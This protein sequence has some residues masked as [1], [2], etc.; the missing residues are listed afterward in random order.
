MTVAG[1][2]SRRLHVAY[3][4]YYVLGNLMAMQVPFVGFNVLLQAECASSH[5]IFVMVNGFSLMVWFRNKVSARQAKFLLRLAFVTVVGLTAFAILAVILT[6]R[7]Q[8]TGRALSL[9][10]PTYAK[11]YIPIIASVSEHQPTTWTS[12]FFDLHMLVPFAPAG[13]FFLFENPTDGKIF[14][15]LYGT[16]AWYF[17]GVMVRLMLT[18]APV[19]S[20]LASVGVSALLRRFMGH[21]KAKV[22]DMLEEDERGRREERDA[23]QKRAARA[24]KKRRQRSKKAGS[25][26]DGED[27]D[28]PDADGPDA[29][30]PDAD[31]PD[32]D[33]PDATSDAASDPAWGP[34]GA[35]TERGLAEARAAEDEM[36]LALDRGRA[37]TIP[38]HLAAVIVMGLTGL[39]CF[40]SMHATYVASEAYSSPSI[41][42]SSRRADGTRVIMDDYREAYY[43]LRQNTDADAKV[44]SWWDYGYQMAA[45]S[46]R[47]TLVDNNT[48][49]N[50]H[51]AT[52]ARA[53]ASSEEDAW[54]VLDS[55]DVDYVLVVFGGKTGYQS[56]DINK[57]L[58]MVRI[59]QGVYEDITEDIFYNEKG[60]F[61][62]DAT[63]SKRMLRSLLYKTSYYRFSELTTDY[64]QPKGYDLVRN[65]EVG[66]RHVQLE[67]I[68][69][70]FT[71]QNW[72]VRLYR[73]KKGHEWNR[74]QTARILKKNRRSFRK[75][76]KKE[77]RANAARHGGYGAYDADS[78]AKAK[79]VGCFTSEDFFSEDK[80]YAGG[81]TGARFKLAKH[82]AA[83]NK[84]KYFAVARAY[85]DG[86]SFAFD[87]LLVKDPDREGGS[88]DRPCLDETKRRCGCI[89]DF[90][91]EAM[92]EGEVNNRRWS[93]YRLEDDAGAGDGGRGHGGEGRGGRGRGGHA[94]GGHADSET[95][96]E[97]YQ[98][99]GEALGRAKDIYEY[100][101]LAGYD[102]A[103][104]ETYRER[105]KAAAKAA[106]MDE[107]TYAEEYFA[108]YKERY[109]DYVNDDKGAGARG[110]PE[111][112][113]GRAAEAR[114]DERGGGRS[115]ADSAAKDAY[116]AASQAKDIY[117]YL[118]L[119]GYDDEAI[120]MYK[121]RI[122]AAAEA[123]GLTEEE[124]ASQYMEKLANYRE[125]QLKKRAYDAQRADGDPYGDDGRRKKKKKK[126]KGKKKIV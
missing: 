41:V 72:I 100:L 84:K 61:A 96:R 86:H 122:V 90:C 7:L 65:V 12:F 55:L 56:D 21:L 71:S 93:V 109:A 73:V 124:Y 46:N 97:A 64:G 40:Y 68:E 11:K 15:I 110:A 10:D 69:E 63:A 66:D 32:A 74:V 70:A 98:K 67:H 102:D 20:I 91:D 88:C 47:T 87:E 113:G 119:A 6:G 118:R 38:G 104:V 112:S 116:E 28:G 126:K 58:W 60:R 49:N 77:A 19:A 9:L 27:A 59:A 26:P 45:M 75:E 50:T 24:R 16:M 8:F 48:W 4:T 57:F 36:L 107:A 13:M 22:A 35:P 3:C 42:L 54:P 78:G 121:E 33:G 92:P 114:G 43:W 80:I 1:R 79:Y 2:F 52:V 23:A 95:Y 81:S 37:A 101:E 105:L 53:L 85:S 29:D 99:L 18:L 25:G 39:L 51:I 106:G 89:D 34:D 44:L 30:G 125:A 76:A 120:A 115:Y 103:T 123:A 62:V 31:G 108:K 111:S 5:G 17:A 117:E 14:L 83:A 82:H 94:G